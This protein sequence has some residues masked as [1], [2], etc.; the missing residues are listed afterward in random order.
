MSGKYDNNNKLK[1]RFQFGIEDKSHYMVQVGIYFRLLLLVLLLLFN[2]SCH[3]FTMLTHS[4]IYLKNS[5]TNSTITTF[6]LTQS[7]GLKILC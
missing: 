5:L 3:L 1:K 4:K 2:K 6:S 7:N